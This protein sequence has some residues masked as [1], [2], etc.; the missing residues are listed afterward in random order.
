MFAI[1]DYYYMIFVICFIYIYICYYH[2]FVFFLFFSLSYFPICFT[3]LGGNFMFRTTLRC[4]GVGGDG[5]VAFIICLAKTTFNDRIADSKMVVFSKSFR[6]LVQSPDRFFSRWS[7][8]FGVA[9]HQEVPTSCFFSLN[10]D[11]K[12]MVKLNKLNMLYEPIWFCQVWHPTICRNVTLLEKKNAARR[13]HLCSICTATE[14]SIILCECR[15]RNCTLIDSQSLGWWRVAVVQHGSIHVMK[16]EVAL[17]P[18]WFIE[19]HYIN[20]F[21][22]LLMCFFVYVEARIETP[23]YSRSPG[24]SRGFWVCEGCQLLNTLPGL[25][26]WLVVSASLWLSIC[27]CFDVSASTSS[28]FFWQN[29]RKELRFIGL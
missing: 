10:Q 24:R 28:I 5:L 17:R 2:V 25:P 14:R 11:S 27:Q 12:S 19:Y 13:C 21:K 16:I 20:W 7:I 29:K 26:F 23:I 8:L 4:R 22:V 6:D 15:L 9:K 18:K 1:I 3:C